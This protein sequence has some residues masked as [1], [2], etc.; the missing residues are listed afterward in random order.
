MNKN[1]IQ[2]EWVESALFGDWSDIPEWAHDA[3]LDRASRR[4]PAALEPGQ[5]I[6]KAPAAKKDAAPLL[7]AADEK[8]A[9]DK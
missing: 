2:N 7:D 5:S 3:V 8:W 4:N 1:P 9:I 6:P